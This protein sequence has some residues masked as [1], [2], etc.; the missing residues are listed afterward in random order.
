MRFRV[1]CAQH[2]DA[3]GS[4]R[5]IARRS[6]RAA[7]N[8]RV[9]LGMSAKVPSSK[10][11]VIYGVFL[12]LLI[13]G[14]FGGLTYGTVQL[15]NITGLISLNMWAPGFWASN[16]IVTGVL[17]FLITRL[18]THLWHMLLGLVTQRYD[19]VPE[20]GF[21]VFLT[22]DRYPDLYAAVA[23]VGKLVLSPTPDEIRLTHRPDC[24]AVELRSFAL[25]TDRRLVLVIG[26][27]QLEVMT[28]SEMKVIIA[29]ELAHFG[30]GDTPFERVRVSFLESLRQAQQE[31][32]WARLGSGSTR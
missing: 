14:Y 19:T 21:R 8:S 1:L 17:L 28:Q 20:T 12:V 3:G 11:V 16:L 6:T 13:L 31:K 10:L 26:M 9:S 32:P 18:A 23:E 29:H 4:R 5:S 30:G 22:A 7:T 24:Y 15:L 25:Q 2:N 27:P